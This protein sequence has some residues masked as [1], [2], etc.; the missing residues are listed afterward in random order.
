M[1][2]HYQESC[3]TL[4]EALNIGFFPLLNLTPESQVDILYTIIKLSLENL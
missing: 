3:V 4:P 2:L 1:D